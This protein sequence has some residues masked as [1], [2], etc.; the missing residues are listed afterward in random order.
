[1]SLNRRQ[2]LQNVPLA[3]LAA[4][5]SR[6]R[7]RDLTSFIEGERAAGVIPGASVIASKRGKKALE[8]QTGT[9]CS[10]TRRDTPLDAPVIHPFFSYS[11]LVAATVVVMAHQDGLV[12][13][14]A[15]V[16]TYI[17]EFVGGGKE[18][19]TI[20]RLLTHS[21]GIPSAPF[22]PVLKEE[23]W[24]EAVNIACGLKTE[25]E[26][27]SRTSYHALTGLF[28]AAEAVRRKSGNKP[29]A[30]ICRERL[31]NPL[32]ARSLTFGLPDEDEP[33]AL[34]PQPAPGPLPRRLQDAFQ[35]AGHPAGGCFGTVEDALK[36]L[37][38]HL[39]QGKW[40]QRR[41]IKPESL[42]EM[43]KVQYQAEIQQA[44]AAGKN[45]THEPWGL[46][47]LMR[48]DGA[49]NGGHDWFGFRDQ[50]NPGV[51]G[52]AGIDTFIGVADPGTGNALIFVTTN[53]PK[54][55]EKTVPLRNGVTNRVFATLG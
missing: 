11:K 54:P 12:D 47:P 30:Q 42:A 17:P 9:Y 49:K 19:V 31:F 34:T 25:W 43:H 7:W 38:L 20:R 13:Y 52:H 28:I 55:A 5:D 3:A 23:A 36:V 37:Q 46:G 35:F 32:G 10:L 14:D 44:R 45:P 8:W 33:V 1:M 39:N 29:W 50:T 48:G 53:S 6:D 2:L 16:S 4:K 26:P 18:K 21:A 24:K 40:K 27:G 51:F 22:G 41:L 15:P